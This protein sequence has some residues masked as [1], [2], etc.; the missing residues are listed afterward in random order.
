LK[1]TN[2]YDK[3]NVALYTRSIIK[4]NKN[5][6]SELKNSFISFFEIIKVYSEDEEN[7]LKNKLIKVF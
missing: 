5:D 3:N 4:Y 7:K 1:I 2:L 6:Y